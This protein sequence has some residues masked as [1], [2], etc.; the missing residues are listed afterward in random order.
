MNNNEQIVL[1]FVTDT[2]YYDT[3]LAKNLELLT[4]KNSSID[5]KCIK[6][7]S[8][9]SNHIDLNQ[10]I[11]SN[12]NDF[13]K[14]TSDIDDNALKLSYSYY[15]SIYSQLVQMMKE[16][17]KHIMK[18]Q[19]RVTFLIESNDKNHNR[20]KSPNSNISQQEVKTNPL[21]EQL[22]QAQI[23]EIMENDPYYLLILQHL[24]KFM[25]H[26]DSMTNLEVF[27]PN[28]VTN[29]L[30][31]FR[32]NEIQANKYFL[33]IYEHTY[34]KINLKYNKPR[35]ILEKVFLNVLPNK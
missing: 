35:F 9:L 8:E 15:F 4:K 32:N 24:P 6:T 30:R 11:E 21:V 14:K 10:D 25:T 2:L 7:I 34:F 29:V 23:E 20:D 13:R 31:Q 18:T 5:T 16:Y 27:I 26:S 1:N 28:K 33:V 22:T 12:Y 19:K 17:P 3:F